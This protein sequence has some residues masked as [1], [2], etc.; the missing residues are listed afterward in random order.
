MFTFDS[1]Q[2]G[3]YRNAYPILKKYGMKGNLMLVAAQIDTKNCL[4]SEQ[5][6]EMMADGW[7]LGS[8]GYWGVDMINDPSKIGEEVGMS[9]NLLEEK[10]G[11]DIQVFAYPGGI[12]DAEGKMASRV[13]ANLYKAA[14]GIIFSIWDVMRSCVV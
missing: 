12:T 4:T 2:L 8:S 3:Q 11:V 10:F 9:K 14:F 6:K 13:S 5:V 1:S 7:E